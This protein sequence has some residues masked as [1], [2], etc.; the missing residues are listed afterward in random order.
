MKLPQTKSR[1]IILTIIV[2]AMVAVLALVGG[3]WGTA[4]ASTV[5]DPDGPC[6]AFSLS[7]VLIDSPI[8]YA[9]DLTKVVS[10]Q[11]LKAGSTFLICVGEKGQVAGWT[12][13]KL[14]AYSEVPLYVP[15]GVFSAP[16]GNSDQGF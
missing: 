12:G 6:T 16:E 3:Q 15:N 10:G 9:A 11:T 8:Y 2:F 7:T 13:F 1:R 4:R 14:A 5:P